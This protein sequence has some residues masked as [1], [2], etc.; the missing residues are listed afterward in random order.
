MAKH[1]W[2]RESRTASHLLW[3]YNPRPAGTGAASSTCSR[4]DAPGLPLQHQPGRYLPH[5]SINNRKM[6]FTSLPAE[7]VVL[8]AAAAVFRDFDRATLT[9]QLVYSPANCPQCKV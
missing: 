3:F 8:G 5:C 7:C 4:R 1:G 9:G 2:Q 6:F